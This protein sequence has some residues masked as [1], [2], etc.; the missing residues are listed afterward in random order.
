MESCQRSPLF[1]ND[2]DNGLVESFSKISVRE[3]CGFS[4]RSPLGHRS[5]S[6]LNRLQLLS[7]SAREV[8]SCGTVFCFH[9]HKCLLI[10]SPYFLI[11]LGVGVSSQSQE[12]FWV[13]ALT[14]LR[15]IE[16]SFGRLLGLGISRLRRGIHIARNKL[17]LC[18][19][20][21]C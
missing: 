21:R 4:Y 20:T 18:L 14:E 17:F 19:G 7:F 3:R 10:I 16:G 6:V 8:S 9:R 11:A 1:Q 5:L 12:L 13:L 15:A 2:L